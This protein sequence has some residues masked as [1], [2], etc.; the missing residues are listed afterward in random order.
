[1]LKSIH[2]GIPAFFSMACASTMPTAFGE[3]TDV[4]SKNQASLSV[5]G[6]G[7]AVVGT[8]NG[9]S[10][11]VSA[12]GGQA[13]V[14][15]GLGGN[16]EIGVSGYG[17][18]IMSSESGTSAIASGGA[19]LSYKIAPAPWFALVLGGGMIDLDGTC[20][21]GGDVGVLFATHVTDTMSVYSG[22]RGAFVGYPSGSGAFSE[23]VT[24]PVGLSVGVADNVKL[25]AEGGLVV[26]WEQFNGDDSLSSDAIVGGY[27]TFA[28]QF[29]FG[30][31]DELA[32]K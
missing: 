10:G 31:K 20:G 6:G 27:G 13:R 21:G 1:M 25:I 32:K 23:S 26:G 4:L 12:V 5:M 29:M 30:D 3:S 9:C 11:S 24:V 19:E 16:Q 22:A 17:A 18:A 7:G 2:L 8:C 28:I 14:R 15:Y